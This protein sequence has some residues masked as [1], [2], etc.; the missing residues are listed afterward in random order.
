MRIYRLTTV[1]RFLLKRFKLVLKGLVLT[2]LAM[3]V[4][5]VCSV[6]TFNGQGNII[7]QATNYKIYVIHNTLATNTLT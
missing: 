7:I 1:A 4:S 5:A 2:I 6:P 3:L